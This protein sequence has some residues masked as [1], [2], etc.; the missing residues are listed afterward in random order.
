M[1]AIVV[2]IVALLAYWLTLRPYFVTVGCKDVALS[3]TGYTILNWKAWSFNS[4]NQRNYN[5]IYELCM[6]KEGINP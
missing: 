2:A 3:E 5:F 4:N 1:V 6:Q